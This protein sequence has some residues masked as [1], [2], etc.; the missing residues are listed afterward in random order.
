MEVRGQ[1]QAMATL[2]PGKATMA[3]IKQEADW[4]P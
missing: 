2:P 4:A 1:L 3:A